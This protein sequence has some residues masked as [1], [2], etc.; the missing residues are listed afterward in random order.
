MGWTRVHSITSQKM[1]KI[2]NLTPFKTDPVKRRGQTKMT[3]SKKDS[4]HLE[5]HQ[6]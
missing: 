5:I 3:V 1:D 6:P 4:R 2:I